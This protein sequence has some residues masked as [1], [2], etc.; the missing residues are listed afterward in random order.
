MACTLWIF[1]GGRSSDVCGATDTYAATTDATDTGGLLE[2]NTTVPGSI[3]CVTA[4]DWTAKAVV[5]PLI[6][7][8]GNVVFN[9]GYT[10][11]GASTHYNF[12]SDNPKSLGTGVNAR[13]ILDVSTNGDWAMAMVEVMRMMVVPWSRSRASTSKRCRVSCGVSTAVG[14]SRNSSS[15]SSTNARASAARLSM[16]P[17]NSEGINAPTS[18]SSPTAV[19]CFSA[20]ASAWASVCLRYQKMSCPRMVHLR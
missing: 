10:V 2:L 19:S 12:R 1:T 3:I 6:K 13:V 9:Q 8:C 18:A 20:R 7:N 4:V 16:P 14:S 11:G 5:T 15:G 17:L